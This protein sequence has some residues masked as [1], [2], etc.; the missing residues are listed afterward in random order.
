MID[1]RTTYG[2]WPLPN[3][4]NRLY[5]DV[6]RLREAIMLADDAVDALETA[7]AAANASLA[8]HAAAPDP[9]GQYLTAAEG[10]AAYASL[11]AID[12]AVTAIK[13]R[14]TLEANR[15]SITPALSEILWSSDGGGLYLGDGS[16]TGG[17]IAKCDAI[18]IQG[19][20]MNSS[21]PST[22]D[23][24]VWG[25]S[26]WAPGLA[27]A[28][29]LQGRS[30]GSAAPSQY[31]ALTWDGSSWVP[32]LPSASRLQGRLVDPA[33]PNNNRDVLTWDAAT[34]KWAAKQIGGVKAHYMAEA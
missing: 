26:S 28:K 2:G 6:A 34:S 30:V 15:L 1:D 8:A 4:A 20:D 19:R 12:G 29:K 17:L 31:D 11:S 10:N 3:S 21:A 25:G 9:H 18:K 24:V 14:K 16:S 5:E 13:V 32:G 23:S 33:A 22:D 7:I 27:N